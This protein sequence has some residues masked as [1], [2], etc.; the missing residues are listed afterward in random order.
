MLGYKLSL[1]PHEMS[2]NQRD[3][4]RNSCIGNTT[5]VLREA[6][7]RE[8]L[9]SQVRQKARNAMEIESEMVSGLNTA[10]ESDLFC[11]ESILC[12]SDD[13]ISDDLTIKNLKE[14]GLLPTRLE[15][16]HEEMLFRGLIPM[17][18]VCN[19]Y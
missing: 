2:A 6:S 5:F 9:L 17:Y 7:L 8:T 19:N 13:T 16:V 12:N 4:V 11:L 1:L 10:L 14:K 18:T 15:W 3:I